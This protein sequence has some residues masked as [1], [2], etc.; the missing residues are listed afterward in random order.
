MFR[1]PNY[2]KKLRASQVKKAISPKQSTD[3]GGRAP[4]PQANKPTSPQANKPA[5]EQADKPASS[6]AF[7][8]SRINK[9]SI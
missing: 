1:H 7:S 4:S 8:G 5:S 3:S 9:R 6:Q 2:Y